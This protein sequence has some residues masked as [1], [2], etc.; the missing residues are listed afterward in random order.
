M[1][2]ITYYPPPHVGHSIAA[3][4][5]Q[6]LY[7]RMRQ[8]AAIATGLEALAAQGIDSGELTADQLDHMAHLSGH[9]ADHLRQLAG[10]FA[11]AVSG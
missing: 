11:E 8:G 2:R 10:L 3:N 5:R 4:H 9:L 6:T 7:T 1:P